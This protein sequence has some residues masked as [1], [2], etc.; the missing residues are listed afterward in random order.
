MARIRR[1]D[2]AT[3][4]SSGVPTRNFQI[5]VVGDTEPYYLSTNNDPKGELMFQAAYTAILTALTNQLEV[6]LDASSARF[7]TQVSLRWT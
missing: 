4:H 5:Y 3:D 7:L 1:V 6:D 2:V